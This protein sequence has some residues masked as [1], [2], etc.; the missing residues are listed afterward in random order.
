MAS[1]MRPRQESGLSGETSRSGY[2][3]AEEQ[4]G[5]ALNRTL[6]Y[7]AIKSE[8]ESYLQELREQSNGELRQRFKKKMNDIFTVT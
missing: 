1:S 2:L 7:N 6:F 5:F 8:F 4:D 3:V